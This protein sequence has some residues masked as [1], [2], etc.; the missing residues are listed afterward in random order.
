VLCQ[1]IRE[2]RVYPQQ[3][4]FHAGFRKQMSGLVAFMKE[5][6][7]LEGEFWEKKRADR[8]SDGTL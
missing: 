4:A 3:A 1:S 7:V 6:W 8:S 5:D 2:K